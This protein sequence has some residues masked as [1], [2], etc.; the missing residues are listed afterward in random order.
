MHS[1]KDKL[2]RTWDVEGTFDGWE[3]VHSRHGVNLFDIATEERQSLLQLANPFTRGQV[4]WTLVEKQA[5]ARG[6]TPEQFYAG[7]DG[8][9]IEQSFQA[10]LDEMIF[11]SHQ[12]A[13]KILTVVMEKVRMAEAAAEKVVDQKMPTLAAAMDEEIES[14][15]SGNLATSLPE[16]SESTLADGPSGDSSPSSKAD[17]ENSGTT[18]QP[19]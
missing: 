18:H 9:V 17:S 16:L 12:K 6:I 19:S 4:L 3:R 10:L 8:D 1:F 11:F 13:K 2:G 14:W 15:I 5:E 7:F